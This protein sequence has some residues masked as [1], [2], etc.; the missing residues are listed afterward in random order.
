MESVDVILQLL[1]VG[2]LIY[3]IYA[4]YN[5]VRKNK[6]EQLKQEQEKEKIAKEMLLEERKKECLEWNKKVQLTFKNDE[7]EQL[8]KTNRKIKAL[9]GDYSMNVA[10]NTNAILKRL[11]IETEFVPNAHNIIDKIN[12]GNNYDVI[13][14]N[15]VYP[16]GESGEQVLDTLKEIEGFDT[17]IIILTVDQNARKKYVDG[18][19]FDEYMA[20]PLDIEKATTTLPKVIKNLKFTKIKSNKS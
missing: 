10:P 5:E 1:L 17:P 9:V 2:V 20:K 6:E 11:G 14:T 4:V 19:G 18:I 12:D 13:I 3:V 16:H 8:Y 15:N 7:N